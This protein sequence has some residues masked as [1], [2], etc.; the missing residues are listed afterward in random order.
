MA[1]SDTP[2]LGA[3]GFADAVSAF[4]TTNTLGILAVLDDLR[5]AQNV[6]QPQVGMLAIVDGV[7]TQNAVPSTSMLGILAVYG[8][9]ATEDFRLRAWGYTQ[10]GHKFYVLHLGEQGTWVYDFTTKQWAEWK[11]QGFDTG[12]NA[13]VGQNWG[14]DDRVIAGDRQNG[15]IWEVD[16]DGTL[17]EGFKDVVRE[18]TAIIPHSGF[19]WRT[20]DTLSLYAS[21]G[22]PTGLAPTIELTYSDDQGKTYD[23][24]SDSLTVLVPGENNQDLSWQSLGSFQAP[25]RIINIK[26]YGGVVRIDRAVFEV[27]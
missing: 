10:D 2:L 11:T 8:E 27:R 14:A 15:I 21:V 4:T 20:L 12:W 18:V 9:G 16:P 26:D 3:L 24:P 6:K 1:F 13:Y 22:T 17:D 25:G 19:T 23:A 5:S 7:P